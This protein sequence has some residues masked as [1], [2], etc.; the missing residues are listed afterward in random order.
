[1]QR[2]LSDMGTRFRLFPQAPFLHP[3][4]L[5]EIVYV[6][7][8]P[9][10]IGAGPSDDRLYVIDPL[11]KTA[12]YGL[13]PELGPTVLYLP[14]WSGSIRPPVR[15]GPDGHFDHIPL[16]TPEFAL[17]HVYG[18]TRFVMDIWERYFGGPIPW[19]FSRHFRRLEITILPILDNARAGYG[20]MEV[21]EHPNEDG[22]IVP[23]ALNFDVIAHEFG[24]LIIYGTLGVPNLAT[25][26]GEY[27]GFHESA[28]DMTALIASLHFA[29]MVDR[30]LDDTRGNLYALNELNRFAELSTSDQ[31]RLASNSAKLSQFAAGWDDEHDLSQPLTGA[32]FDTLVDIFQELLVER[33]LIA[34]AVADLSD[35]VGEYPAY[36][37]AVQAAFDAAYPGRA[38]AFRQ[39]L[40]DARDY[41][42]FALAEVWKR[43][44]PHFLTYA[45]VGDLLIAVDQAMS[46]GRYRAEIYESFA[47]REIGSVTVG[48][49]LAPPDEASHAVSV[50][51]LVPAELDPTRR[52]FY[53]DV[54][55]ARGIHPDLRR[56][57]P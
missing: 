44:S 8:P 20:Y 40:F 9:G 5:P 34:R 3:E 25:G 38:R 1:M 30:L 7:R 29:S 46:G 33:G 19:H 4:L 52:L 54:L 13:L 2:A 24:H 47:W 14:P 21:G 12:A 45:Q 27:F 55:S 51:A 26:Q 42:G 16:G 36:L 56:F 15:P 17:A 50:R 53:Q 57:M 32:L 39:A 22:T 41:L 23:Y 37:P 31:I 11:G 49:R 6:S 18:T 28:A 35:L 48:P 43:L 10:S